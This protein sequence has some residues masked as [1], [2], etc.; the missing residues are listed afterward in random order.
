[1]TIRKALRDGPFN[2]KDLAKDMGGSYGTLR[3]WS[4]G[5]R[6]PTDESVQRIA[7]AFEARGKKL[8]E[9]AAKMRRESAEAGE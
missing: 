1:M 2:L 9:L 7:A 6:L 8:M 3:E 4:R 5:A